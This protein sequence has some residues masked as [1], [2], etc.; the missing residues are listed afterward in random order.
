S[1]T[2]AWVGLPYGPM[3]LQVD[4]HKRFSRDSRNSGEDRQPELGRRGGSRRDDSGRRITRLNTFRRDMVSPPVCGGAH[5]KAPPLRWP[6]I[7][8]TDIPAGA[9][10]KRRGDAAPVRVLLGGGHPPA[11]SF[12]RIVATKLRTNQCRLSFR[13]PGLPGRIPL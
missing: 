1:M 5:G 8:Y 7:Q 11:A 3:L 2:I 9:Q 10:T 12:V 13:L 4:K 6:A